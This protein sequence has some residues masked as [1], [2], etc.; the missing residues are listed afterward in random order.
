VDAGVSNGRISSQNAPVEETNPE[1][2]P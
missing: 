2:T 1:D